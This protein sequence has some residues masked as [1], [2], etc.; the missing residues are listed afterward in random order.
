MTLAQLIADL[1]HA[2]G[3]T[4]DAEVKIICCE[5]Q[6]ASHPVTGVTVEDG[7]LIIDKQGDFPREQV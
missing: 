3:L 5:S 4:G 1:R 2:E 7:V 6:R